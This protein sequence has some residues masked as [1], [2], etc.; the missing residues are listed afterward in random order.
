M[1]FL[2]LSFAYTVRYVQI[3]VFD[4]VCQL[5]TPFQLPKASRRPSLRPT[6]TP[7]PTQK[8]TGPNGAGQRPCSFSCARPLPCHSPHF[9]PPRWRFPVNRPAR[10][11][12]RCSSP[13][14]KDSR[15]RGHAPEGQEPTFS[16]PPSTSPASALQPHATRNP[17]SKPCPARGRAD[18]RVVCDCRVSQSRA[19]TPHTH[20]ICTRELAPPPKAR[21]SSPNPGLAR[22]Q[23]AAPHRP[24]GTRHA[25]PP[26]PARTTARRPPD[27][28]PTGPLPHRHAAPPARSAARLAATVPGGVACAAPPHATPP[29]TARTART[30]TRTH[31]DEEEPAVI[32]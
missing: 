15:A 29:R 22:P 1:S 32:T 17:A 9:H 6:C 5:W 2:I 10:T 3:L 27:R 21:R 25:T 28:R 26:P 16:I 30:H 23:H 11:S 13:P 20:L 7:T 8:S 12:N 14:N 19:C 24:A 4:T 31:G 18:G